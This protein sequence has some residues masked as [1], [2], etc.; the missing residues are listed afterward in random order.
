[1]NISVSGSEKRVEELKQ[2]IPDSVNLKILSSPLQEDLAGSEFYFDLNLDESPERL[3]TLYSNYRGILVASAVKKSL[4]DIISESAAE[5]SCT[6]VGMNCLPTFIH[7]SV[8]EFS[9]IDAESNKKVGELSKSL[10]WEYEIVDDRCGMVS[11]RVIFMIINEAYYT[12][13][14]GTADKAAIDK[15]MKLGTNYPMGPF[16]WSEKIGLHNILQTLEAVHSETMDER[17][18]IAPLL[19]KEAK[20]RGKQG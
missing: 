1:M 12:L 5:P 6:L 4:L 8:K 14:E 2:C 19:R 10:G 9:T 11:P 18:K 17:Y 20:Y 15:A 13:Q 3:N 7:R 16:E